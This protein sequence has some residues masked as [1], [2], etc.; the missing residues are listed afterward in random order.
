MRRQQYLPS[1]RRSSVLD[2]SNETAV[3]RA[4]CHSSHNCPTGLPHVKHLQGMMI[5]GRVLIIVSLV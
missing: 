1:P 5:S 2:A 4:S 3:R